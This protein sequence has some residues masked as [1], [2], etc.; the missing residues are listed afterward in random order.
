MRTPAG[1]CIRT[2]TP[3]RPTRRRPAEAAPRRPPCRATT[4]GSPT[5][6]SEDVHEHVPGDCGSGDASEDVLAEVFVL[7]HALEALT[8]V[9]GRYRDGGLTELGRLEGE[10][11]EHP[12]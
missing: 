12:L 7:E 10:I 11:V 3:A 1:G 2:R 9:S 8:H 6:S 5:R 4:P